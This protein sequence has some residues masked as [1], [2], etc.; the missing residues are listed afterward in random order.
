MPQK[1]CNSYQHKEGVEIIFSDREVRAESFY[2]WWMTD[3]GCLCLI[4]QTV[5]LWCFSCVSL[6]VPV[7]LASDPVLQH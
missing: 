4:C 5:I 3:L 6:C 2:N 7:A 1:Q